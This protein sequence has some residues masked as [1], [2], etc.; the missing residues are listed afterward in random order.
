MF[1][2][3][4]PLQLL[5]GMNVT[6]IIVSFVNQCVI[7]KINGAAIY[8]APNEAYFQQPTCCVPCKVLL[9]V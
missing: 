7:Q 9:I 6:L 4:F 5:F 3:T 8:G 1:S 2:I